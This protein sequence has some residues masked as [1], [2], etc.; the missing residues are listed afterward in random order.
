MTW[1][2]KAHQAG[3]LLTLALGFTIPIS[4]SLTDL[5]A[6]LILILWFFAGHYKT[7]VDQVRSNPLVQAS[8]LLFLILIVGM[9]YTPVPLGE[10][11]KM[12][13]KYRE[14][15]YLVFFI[16]FLVK[17]EH[18]D[19]AQKAFVLAMLL[20]L[21]VSF[22]K[23]F[24]YPDNMDPA[25]RTGNA[26]KDSIVH[27]FLMAVFAFGLMTHILSKTIARNRIAVA[28][29]VFVAATV[30]LFFM[31]DGRTGFVIYYLLGALLVIQQC[32]WRIAAIGIIALVILH[33]S[34]SW[35]S[36]TYNQQMGRIFKNV[37]VYLES[38]STESSIG[39]RLEYIE[40][41]FYLMAERPMLG[42][43][44]GSFKRQ[45]AALTETRGKGAKTANPHNEYLMIGVQTGLVGIGFLLYFMFCQWKYSFQLT[46][47]NRNLAMGLALVTAVGCMGNSFFLD[48]TEGIFIIYFS[49][50][51]FSPLTRLDKKEN[52]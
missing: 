19:W 45:Y 35:V 52:A 26:F 34:L 27:S 38:G 51:F 46:P 20:T 3:I 4:T 21:A 24:S 32:K 22:Y 40:N 1:S 33:F 10:A 23:F 6:L 48:H 13:K 30:N 42:H 49:A 25:L 18:R 5:L 15:L 31:T 43:G 16:P 29:G 28:I 7:F 12:L 2:G 8:L 11:G 37:Q 36:D 50:V 39:K 41:S 9:F 17:E 14:L 47:L 44:T